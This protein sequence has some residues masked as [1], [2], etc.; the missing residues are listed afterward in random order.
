MSVKEEVIKLIK[1]LPDHVSLDEIMA[2]LYVRAKIEGGLK[3]L[4]QGQG[5][6]HEVVME[7]MN[8][9]IK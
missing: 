5:V 9:W 6:P 8:K 1:Q 2:E 4:D 7:K 3:E